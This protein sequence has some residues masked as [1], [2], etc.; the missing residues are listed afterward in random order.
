MA[1]YFVY[2]CGD[3]GPTARH[4][5]R[6]EDATV[7]DWFRNHWRPFADYD[8]ANA[9]LNELVGVKVYSIGDLYFDDEQP[10]LPRPETLDDVRAAVLRTY[11]NA[12]CFEEHCVQV[13][14][15]DD[16]TDMAFYFFDDVFLLKHRDLAAYVLNEDWR[17][18]EGEGE[19][20]WAAS[21]S[22]RPALGEIRGDGPGCLYTAVIDTC[23]GHHLGDGFAAQHVLGVRVPELCRWLMRL[24]GSLEDHDYH[25]EELRSV[26][27]SKDLTQSRE[28][29]AFLK[30][31]Q[32]D[33]HDDVTWK[34]YGDWTQ[35]QGVRPPGLRLLERALPRHR[36]GGNPKRNL[37][38]V[39]D[40][41]GQLFAH[42]GDKDFE[43]W[44]FFDDLWGNAHPA[45]ANALLRYTR[46]DMLS[47]GNETRKE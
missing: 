26:L 8:S 17:L 33:P 34:V 25:F 30:A 18:P 47:T 38:Q 31:L 13:L 11:H 43:H 3:L 4:L 20:G 9:Y 45:L 22:T 23:G 14:T 35:D 16:E 12:I 27:L 29:R 39:G 41:V 24:P 28:E 46:W 40:R 44:F 19:E 42:E 2:R 32:K 15:D 1:T 37:A 36:S 6:F 10:E 5:K 7:L 21:E